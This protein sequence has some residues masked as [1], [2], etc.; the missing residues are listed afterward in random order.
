MYC[1]RGQ[2]DCN[3]DVEEL[4]FVL[5]VLKFQRTGLVVLVQSIF[6]VGL[7]LL[8]QRLLDPYGSDLEDL[9]VLHYI[10]EA[11]TTSRRVLSTE[12]PAALDADLETTLAASSKSIGLPWEAAMRKKPL[13]VGDSLKLT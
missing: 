8:G 6:V 11:W 3:A 10:E 5:K 12:F 4:S 13:V 9:S 2:R 7:R 1:I